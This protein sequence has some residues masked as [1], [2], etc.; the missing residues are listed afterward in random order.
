MLASLAVLFLKATSGTKNP[1]A[2]DLEKQSE[3]TL[4]CM[5]A[6]VTYL[7]SYATLAPRLPQPTYADLLVCF[8][9]ALSVAN[10]V[11]CVA[12]GKRQTPWLL[13]ILTLRRYRI[14]ALLVSGMIIAAWCVMTLVL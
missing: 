9:L 3:L 11:F 12:I 5:L 14:G 7:I 2:T 13:G 10:F 1:S 6:V 8:T 4:V